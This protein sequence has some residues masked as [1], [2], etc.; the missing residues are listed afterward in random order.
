[1]KQATI[2]RSASLEGVGLHTGKQV[3]LTFLPA[4]EQHGIRFQR[5]DLPDQPVVPADISR[6][7]STQR[8]TT[9]TGRRSVR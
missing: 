1:M 8:G 6:V 3:K 7:V 4:P 2:Q 9:I 5:T